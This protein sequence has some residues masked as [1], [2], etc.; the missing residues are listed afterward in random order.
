[1]VKIIL[2]RILYITYIYKILCNILC[3]CV[4]VHIC[5][6]ILPR[7]KVFQDFLCCRVLAIIV[8]SSYKNVS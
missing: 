1:M 8:N 4:C 5:T 2:Q 3:A 7:L 6:H